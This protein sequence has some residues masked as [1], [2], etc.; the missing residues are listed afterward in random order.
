MQLQYTIVAFSHLRWNF[1]YQRPQ[2]LLSRLAAKRPVVFIEEPEFDAGGPPRWERSSPSSNL[3][4]Y[5]PRTPVA[6]P[7]FHGDQLPVL[8][9]MMAE[10][11]E[12]LGTTNLLTWLYTPMALP[13]AL[14]LDPDAAV[15]DCMDELSLFLGAPPE[16]LTLE[17]QLLEYADVMFTGGPSLFRAKQSRH[18]NVHCFPSSVDA[19][20]FRVRERLTSEAEDQAELPHPRLGFYGVIDERLD[21]AIVDRLAEAHPDW[22]IVL[23]GPVVKIDPA[24]LPRRPNLHYLGQR[25]YEELPRYL[26]GWDVCLLP[27]ARNDATRFISPTKTL[28]YM[29]AELPI[30]ST[31]IRDVADVYG[32]IVYLGDTPDEFLAACEQALASSAQERATRAQRMRKVLAGTSWEATASAME[33][34][35]TEAVAGRMN[36]RVPA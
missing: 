34:L 15:Y 20:H 11:R 9:P 25:S 29:A 13:L 24:S 6:A 7:G 14:A 18:P 3:T 21:L 27:F 28:E 19:E 33:Q 2:H 35:L 36:F 23:V 26:A 12:E 31:S 16:L 30:V 22:Q 8:E 17:S 4:V 1:V 5:R 32:D 10:L